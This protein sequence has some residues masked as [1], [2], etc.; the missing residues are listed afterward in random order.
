MTHIDIL[1]E[2][3][4]AIRNKYAWPG[5]Y[6]LFVVLADGEALSCDAAR[7]NWRQ[8]VS[9]TISGT[10]LPYDSWRAAGVEINW[11]DT[12]LFC[13]HSGARIESAY[14]EDA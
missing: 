9:A 6:P 3:K 2:V 4:N 1:K 5:G 12:D 11:E 10:V 14:G 13:A 8:I 7:E